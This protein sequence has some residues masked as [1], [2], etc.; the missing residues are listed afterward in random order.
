MA[1]KSVL[2]KL[3]RERLGQVEVYM[4]YEMYM[5]Y[6]YVLCVCNMPFFDMP[7]MQHISSIYY[8]TPRGMYEKDFQILLYPVTPKA[9]PTPT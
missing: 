4:Y 6:V 7:N 1:V 8:P 3:Y 5:Q 9:E 2:A